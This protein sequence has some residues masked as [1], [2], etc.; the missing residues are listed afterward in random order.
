MACYVLPRDVIRI[1][2][3]DPRVLAIAERLW[4]PGRCGAQA[5]LEFAIDVGARAGTALDQPLSEHWTIGAEDVDFSLGARMHGRIECA[6]GRLT[7]W[8]EPDLLDEHPSQIARLM[9][10]TPAAVMLARRSYGVVHAGAVAGPA[11]AVVIRG[12]P[13]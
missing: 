1:H 12:A 13:G 5:P 10:E 11:G 8:I 9:L 4:E 3:N 7:G 6:R 2:T